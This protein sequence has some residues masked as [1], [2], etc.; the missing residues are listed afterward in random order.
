MPCGPERFTARF[1]RFVFRVPRQILTLIP[2]VF[3]RLAQSGL[4]HAV[5]SDMVFPVGAARGLGV[6]LWCVHGLHGPV[7][8]IVLFCSVIGSPSRVSDGWDGCPSVLCGTCRGTQ[9]TWQ[10]AEISFINFR[11]SPS[12]PNVCNS[13]QPK[14][15]CFVREK[16]VDC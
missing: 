6:W 7:H 15:T 10:S 14:G 11:Q 1:M 5:V 2:L 9:S 16:T 12:E 3:V 13:R 8:G 4:R